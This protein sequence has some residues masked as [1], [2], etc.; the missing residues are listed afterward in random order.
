MT[1]EGLLRSSFAI[2]GQRWD[3]E[4]WSVI[5]EQWAPAPRSAD[6]P[7]NPATPDQRRGDRR[8]HSAIEVVT[9]S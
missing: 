6:T 2:D 3:N 1:R 9:G 8:G 7:P 5:F 4:V